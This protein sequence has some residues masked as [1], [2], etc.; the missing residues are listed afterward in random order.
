MSW[1]E[2]RHA[3]ADALGTALAVEL[4]VVC[5]TAT[6]ARGHA[7]L[8]LAG[9]RTPLPAYQRLAGLPLPWSKVTLLPS[10]ERCVP[11]DHPAC[12]VRELRAVFAPA[13][14]VSIEALTV[15]DGDLHGSERHAR[16]LLAGHAAPWDA[17]VL[18]MGEDG[19]TASL[20]PGTAGLAA[21]LAPD[22]T[23]D[24]CAMMPRPLPVEAPYPRI[25]LTAARLLR[26]RSLH[27]VVTGAR[28][29]AVLQRA[30]TSRDVEELPVSAI[31]HA[32][33][34]LVHIHWSP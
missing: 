21:A 29:L 6:E 33:G 19:H 12:N 5:A 17:V 34:A 25:S 32:P 9:G 23:I 28:K 4:G 18:G 10:D 30:M 16:E 14:G 3:S 7:S 26:T 22:W 2:Q 13:A 27:L 24:A 20:F 11:H 1:L 15:P 31:L 8:V